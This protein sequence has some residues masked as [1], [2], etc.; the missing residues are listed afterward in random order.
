MT[1]QEVH[2]TPPVNTQVLKDCLTWCSAHTHRPRYRS[3]NDKEDM[4][5]SEYSE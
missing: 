1:P 5:V 3:A 4:E 2:T